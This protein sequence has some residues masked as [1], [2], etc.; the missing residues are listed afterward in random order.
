[1]ARSCWIFPGRTVCSVCHV[2]DR[3][4]FKGSQ[5]IRLP[6]VSGLSRLCFCP[7]YENN[8]GPSVF[9]LGG[10]GVQNEESFSENS[11]GTYRSDS[12]FLST[13]R[14]RNNLSAQ[15]RKP[16]QKRSPAHSSWDCMDISKISKALFDGMLQ[17]RICCFTGRRNINR[18]L[19]HKLLIPPVH[20]GT[21]HVRFK[22][23]AI[24]IR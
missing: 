3:T 5:Y 14:D 8:P 12:Y 9:I 7:R 15:S 24:A 23:P 1:M 20:I 13:E 6:L 16:F 2:S 17:E 22:S 19:Q 4:F 18:Q 21:I 11:T 10:S